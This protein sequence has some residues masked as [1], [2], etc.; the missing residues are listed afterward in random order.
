MATGPA[1]CKKCVGLLVFYQLYIT[2]D[3]LLKIY[4]YATIFKNNNLEF[5]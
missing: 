5:K 3:I 4:L 2:F 1:H